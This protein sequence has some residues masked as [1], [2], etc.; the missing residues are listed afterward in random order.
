MTRGRLLTFL[1]LLVCA[2]VVSCGSDSKKT[3]NPGKV[4]TLDEIHPCDTNDPFGVQGS[5]LNAPP[6]PTPV[7]PTPTQ[8]PTPSPNNTVTSS[9]V[10][11]TSVGGTTGDGCTPPDFSQ[12]CALWGKDEYSHAN[13]EDIGCGKT[14]AQCGCAMTAAAG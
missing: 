12:R 3:P 8:T 13:G 2:L 6:T 11:D 5:Q 14:I 4:I 10:T 9:S 7:P 1:I